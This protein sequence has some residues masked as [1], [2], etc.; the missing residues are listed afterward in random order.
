MKHKL[1]PICPECMSYMLY[2]PTKENW[3][4]CSCGYCVEDKKRIVEIPKNEPTN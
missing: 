2:H 1:S 4:K 3:L